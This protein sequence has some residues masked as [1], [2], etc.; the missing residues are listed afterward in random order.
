MLSETIN[1]KEKSMWDELTNVYSVSKTLRFE[2]KPI[3]RTLENIKS[4][5]EN[6]FNLIEEDKQRDKDFLEVKKIIDK[7]LSYFI[8]R[9]LDGSKNIIEEH[10]IKEIQEV[11][12]KLKKDTTNDEL[13]KKYASLQS[14][15]RKEI[16]N[17]IK[18][19]GYYNDFFSKDFI[20]KI[21]LDYYKENEYKYNLLKK[22]ER[23]NTYFTGFYENRK[24]IF[25]DKDISTS[26]T[27]RIINDNLPKF[28]DNVSKFNEI[29][30]KLPILKIEEEFKE[31][32]EGMPL[33]VFFSL[34]NFKNCLNQKGIDIYNLL[35]GGRS[36]DGEKKIKGLN[37]YIN[38][39]A[40]ESENPKLIRKL[41]LMPLYKQ[42]LSEKNS[43]S[44]I[45]EKIYDDRELIEKINNYNQ[46]IENNDISNKIKSLF[47]NLENNE[48]KEI[49]IKNGKTIT[50]L[51]QQIFGDWDKL[52]IGL[53]EYANH[54]LFSKK[55]DKEKWLKKKYFSI[56]E[57]EKA[58]EKLNISQE[59]DEKLYEKFVEKVNNNTTHPICGYLSSFIDKEF[60]L[61]ENINETKNKYHE[62]SIKEFKSGE[63]NLLKQEFETDVE[64]IKAYLDSIKKLL[65]FIEPLYVD[66]SSENSKEQEAF[67]IDS[68]FYETYNELYSNLKEIIPLYNQVR[69]YVTQ[70]PFSTKKFKLNF[71][72][73]TLLNGWDKNK[74]RDNFSIIFKKLNNQGKY[75]Y[76]LGIMSKGNNKIFLNIEKSN[77]KNCFEKM[78]YK[79][80]PGPDKMLPK[81]FFSKT[82][83]KLFSPSSEILEI[84]NHSSHTKGGKAQDGF[85]KKEF[86][87]NDC[88]K[89]IDFYKESIE[90]HSEWKNF[91]FEFRKTIDYIDTSDFFKDIA[92]QGYQIKFKS[93]SEDKI[94]QLVDEGKLYL[95]QI[96][97]KDFSSYSKGR[98]NLHTIYWEELFSE[99]NLKD[100]IY[101]LN[102]EAE[103]FYRE[104]SIQAKPTHPKNEPVE[105]KDPIQGKK[106]SKF[107]YDLIKDKRYTE[108]KFLFHCPI[109]MNFKAKGSKWDINKI[110]NKIIKENENIN[111]I[112]ID[113]GE[114]HLAYWTLLN[115][116]GEIVDQGSFNIITE[117]TIERKT[118]YHQKLNEKEG[119]RDEARK[120]W[121]KIENI[122]ELKEG[123]LSQVVHKI[124]KLAVENN[125]IIVFEDL[126]FGFKRGRF[127][128]EKQVYQKFE[129]MLIEKLNYLMFKD[130]EKEEIAGSLNALQLTPEITKEKEK[131]KQV[132]II[133]YV[134][135]NYTSKIDPKTGFI[136]LLN[137][138]YESIEKAKDLFKKFN[139]IKYNGEYFEFKIDYRR[140]LGKYE[141]KQK[142]WII[143]SYGERIITQR[144][145]DK[146]N[147][148][149]SKVIYPTEELIKLFDEYKID[150]KEKEN[151]LHEILKIN[152]SDFF[153]SLTFILSK[154]LQLR[155]SYTD[156]ELKEKI[157]SGEL[158][159]KSEGDY[160]L[161]CVKD[162]DG[163][164]FDS[165]KAKETE[166]KNA[167]SNGAYNI[168]IKGLMIVN[169]IKNSKKDSNKIKSDDIKITRDEFVNFVIDKNS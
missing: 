133:F 20:K 79:L 57:L 69:N 10:Q 132:G 64:K 124:A 67:E 22:F 154:I 142:E 70:K 114:R 19:K 59:F 52:N 131:G 65:Q 50:N 54:D 147:H 163:K 34:Y 162:K 36:P 109:T 85:N 167:D 61:F 27:F 33:N 168:G 40:Q 164:F 146:N 149:E 42:I 108:D 150:Y 53:E 137:P 102:G 7:Y 99:E 157:N 51:S 49:Y 140:F 47:E 96:Y 106:Y 30:E 103:I 107:N 135:P 56:Y 48:L 32:L 115:L 143:C 46:E 91:N 144:S 55:Q 155:N 123:Y 161:S 77:E 45:F 158:S 25:T 120:N 16:F 35:I 165:R 39:L 6:G 119:S 24:N 80:L 44:F 151:I 98:K 5:K 136:N 126:N 72:N 110:I 166:P 73:S 66:S 127:K 88:H 84:R 14:N 100:V 116:K 37:E 63:K 95:F 62:V 104:K 128:I 29:K 129:K 60:N 89:M 148:F 38:E 4:T 159:N 81:V 125:A 156:S 74:E 94:N 153:K 11:Y 3:G 8:E 169:K 130:R 21:L 43:S 121:K 152:S 113:R 118:N 111:I 134:D 68:H 18:T 86:N 87:L 75:E 28:L 13:K 9:N 92:D 138:K 145:S 97:N 76:F 15:L 90:K 141:I 12:E 41:K 58:I 78:E 122:K 82:N 71:E 26:L 23:W 2:L 117:E 160:I 105:N 112:S 93:I 83:E 139:S 1:K 17:Q 101:K 31:Y